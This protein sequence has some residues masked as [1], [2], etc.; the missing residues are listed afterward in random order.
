MSEYTREQVIEKIEKGESLE[1]LDLS[2]IDLCD[3]N[4]SGA[5]LRGASLIRANLSGAD[6]RG[7]DL[8]GASLSGASLIRA[9]LSEAN[10]IEVYLN[11]ASLFGANL[12]RANLSGADLNRAGLIGANLIEADLNGASLIDADLNGVNLNR[13]NLNGA[14][15]NRANLRGVNLN[16][17]FLNRA[18]LRGTNLRGAK[19][20][21]TNLNGAFLNRANLNWAN[22]NGA[23]LNG[24]SLS[25]ANL[26]SA[27]FEEASLEGTNISGANIYYLKT[28]GWNIEG[29]ICTHIY[30][31]DW[32]SWDDPKGREKYRHDFKPGEFENLHR[33]FPKLELIFQDEYRDIDHRALLAVLGEIN[34]QLPQANIRLRE[35]EQAV[36]NTTATIQAEDKK[37][38]DKITELVP[39]GYQALFDKIDNIE[40]L[41][42]DRNAVE[43]ALVPL[44]LA[45]KQTMEWFIQNHQKPQ[46]P[47]TAISA[48]G[49][50]INIFTDPLSGPTQIGHKHKMTIHAQQYIFSTSEEAEK[51]AGNIID[52]LLTSNDIKKTLTELD[53]VISPQLKDPQ[54]KKWFK[55]AF[56]KFKGSL[57]EI[58][59]PLIPILQAT[60]AMELHEVLKIALG[61]L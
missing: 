22:L 54:K 41:L 48:E 18:N 50:T 8:R 21:R 34:Q 2:R 38:I 19:L 40:K 35:L 52:H 44:S 16:R 36:N 46:A 30:Q 42:A 28:H 47:S 51:V 57:D 5:D 13:A 33:S 53:E 29:I 37:A 14:K 7:A 56:E 25:D 1:G 27:D 20:I 3:I 4:M 17:A 24:A 26:A 9:D 15:L 58:S 11:G 55:K 49:E 45:Q 31:C 10:L 39:K 32:E 12:I 61:L 60:S 59:E 6:F 43:Q 23:S